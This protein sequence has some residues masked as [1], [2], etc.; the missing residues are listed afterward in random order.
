MSKVRAKYKPKSFE[1]DGNSS[2]VSANIYMSMI[3]SEKWN[4][5][6]K[7]QR[8]LYLYCKAQLYAEKRKPTPIANSNVEND[9]DNRLYFTMNKSKWCDTYKL[10]ANGSDN[11]FYKDMNAL[12]KNGFVELVESG[13]HTRTRSIYKLSS[14]WQ[15]KK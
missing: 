9:N 2:D 12:V 6:T 3:M 11:M 7:N 13:K 4:N 5:L 1:S 15:D 8:L 14:K 10:Y